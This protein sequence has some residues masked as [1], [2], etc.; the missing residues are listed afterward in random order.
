MDDIVFVT[1]DSVRY[2]YVDSMEFVSSSGAIP[3]IAAGHYTRPSLASLHSSNI[4]GAIQSKIVTPSLATCLQSEGYTTIGLAPSPQLDPAFGFSNG[5]TH[6]DNFT[7]GSGNPLSNRRS[8][9]REYLGSFD[10][11][12]QIYRRIFPMEAV[13]DGLP[14]DAE[15]VDRAIELFEETEPPRFLWLHLMGTH[16]PY[17]TGDEAVPN[18]LDRKAESVGGGGLFGGKAISEQEHHLI[19]EKYRAALSRADQ[20]IE[21]LVD[22]INSDPMFVFTSDH[23]EELGEQ[24]YYYHQGYRQRVPDTVLR[25][26]VV[27][28]QLDLPHSRCSLIDIPP[29]ITAAVCGDSPDEWLGSDIMESP[30]ENTITVAPWHDTATVAWS[31]GANKLVARDAK[32][33]MQSRGKESKVE[34]SEVPQ[35]IEARLQALGYQ[36]G[37]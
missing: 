36:D 26:P 9:V 11:V 35:D 16:R 1:A 33:S 34:R 3:G 22:Q 14:S 5:F 18:T 6:Y 31:D 25:V 7:S 15:L 28:D 32:V 8:R 17:G 21:R 27:F 4:L 23:G 24:G 12:R 2:D 10:T 29:T 37:G 20:E 30:T 19:E 13:L